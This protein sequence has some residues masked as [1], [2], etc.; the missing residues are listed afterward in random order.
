MNVNLHNYSANLAQFVDHALNQAEENGGAT[1]VRA[2]SVDVGTLGR[3]NSDGIHPV[4][5]ARELRLGDTTGDRAG[6][7]SALFR[8][9]ENKE[10]NDTTRELFRSAV[11]EMFGGE[12]NV[13]ESVR[14][15]MKMEDYGKGRPLTARRILTVKAAIDAAIGDLDY[16]RFVPEIIRQAEACQTTVP[17]GAQFHDLVRDAVD[18]QSATG[19]SDK[20]AVAALFTVSASKVSA[21]K[22][23]IRGNVEFQLNAVQEYGYSA[24]QCE[25]IAK[26]AAFYKLATGCSIYE[27]FESAC[28]PAGKANRLMNYGG[29]FM[30]NVENFRHGLRLMGKFEDWFDGVH[31]TFG[32]SGLPKKT[33][34]QING[35]LGVFLTKKGLAGFERFVF[36]D[37]ASNPAFDLKEKD[38]EKAFGFENNAVTN[39][40]GRG[41]Y[42]SSTATLLQTPAERRRLVFKAAAALCPLASDSSSR[43]A[44]FQNETIFVGRALKHLDEL[45]A[46]ADENA[47]TAENVIRTC[48]P[49]IQNPRSF[50]VDA[51]NDFISEAIDRASA[52]DLG[53]MTPLLLM[54]ARSGETV[55]RVVAAWKNHEHLPNVPHLAPYSA[56]LDAFNGGTTCARDQFLKD[57]VR[58]TGYVDLNADG[59]AAVFNPNWGFTFPGGQP[60][61]EL[62]RS[63]PAIED[64]ANAIAGKIERLCGEGN[65]RQ[66]SAVLFCL[67]Q[68][69]L[70]NLQGGLLPYGIRSNEHSPC[71]FTLSKDADTGTVR[72][73]YSNP[74]P[75]PIAFRWE[76]TVDRDGSVTTTPMEVVDNRANG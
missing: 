30:E 31:A 24:D 53:N 11:A 52:G 7:F 63:G 13:P 5:W 34:S 48:Y 36:E 32:N 6:G 16:G 37:I 58:S 41:F 43:Q 9:R 70:E 25:N 50:T 55:D 44:R 73:V 21:L 59:E 19:C 15:A 35:N 60:R 74:E 3:A 71:E 39:F 1:V 46:L 56:E 29:R 8:S 4:V 66:T 51:V 45:A 64:N 75:F 23:E 14:A 18:Y 2:E 12:D 65:V 54:M 17:K 57:V 27:A 72:I 38:A 67:S 42:T 33:P 20:V 40:I 49:D 61:V 69:G 26:A 28:D 47:L 10:A 62:G 68:A 76:A 22:D